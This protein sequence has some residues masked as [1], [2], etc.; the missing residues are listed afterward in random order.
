MYITRKNLELI[1][2]IMKEFPDV[3]VLRLETE[4]E[5]SGIGSILKLIVTTKVGERNADITF[6]ISGVEDW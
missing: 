1:N 5:A 2:D 3:S 6:E 4:G